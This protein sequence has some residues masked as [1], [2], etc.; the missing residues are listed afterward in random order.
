MWSEV[1]IAFLFKFSWERWIIW[2]S[3][4]V[5]NMAQWGK[6]LVSGITR[7]GD[8]LNFSEVWFSYHL[9]MMVLLSLL[10][11]KSVLIKNIIPVKLSIRKLK[12]YM[13]WGDICNSYKLTKSTL[14]FNPSLTEVPQVY[15]RLLA[16]LTDLWLKF[17]WQESISPLWVL[18][19]QIRNKYSQPSVTCDDKGKNNVDFIDYPKL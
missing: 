1:V 15:I 3:K 5:M 19:G 16:K 18:L 8:S 6:S 17:Y 7:P 2:G 14:V 9:R 13:M 4:N 11:L 10:Q 12:V